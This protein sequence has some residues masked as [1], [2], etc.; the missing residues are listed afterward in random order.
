MLP[1]E[2]PNHTENQNWEG[3]YWAYPH[4]DRHT[5]AELSGLR[6]TPVHHFPLVNHK[7]DTGFPLAKEKN[8]NLKNTKIF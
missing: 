4:P 7:Q 2:Y 8:Q 3:N 1:L 5:C 6:H